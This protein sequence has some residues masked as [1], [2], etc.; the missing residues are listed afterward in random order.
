[1]VTGF[2]LVG[3]TVACRL[4]SQNYHIWNL[5]PAGAVAIYAGARLPRKIRRF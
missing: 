2:L 5:V 4:L 3:L 1:M